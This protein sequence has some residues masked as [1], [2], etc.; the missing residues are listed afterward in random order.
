MDLDRAGPKIDG[1]TL[2]LSALPLELRLDIYE[3]CIPCMWHRKRRVLLDYL[4]DCRWMGTSPAIFHDAAPLVLRNPVLF[5]HTKLEVEGNLNFDFERLVEKTFPNDFQWVPGIAK[6]MV[7]RLAVTIRFPK[8]YNKS[9]N[10]VDRMSE[11]F[12]NIDQFSSLKELYI[13]LGPEYL[14]IEREEF[15]VQVASKEVFEPENVA[16]TPAASP[17][18]CPL[19]QAVSKLKDEIP[20]KCKVAWRFDRAGMPSMPSYIVDRTE[21]VEHLTNVNNSMERLWR[22]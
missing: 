12:G 19:A 2:L 4:V 6:S 7:Q 16:D 20:R 22:Q 17:M 10:L 9:N 18:P 8:F 3:I 13:S 21:V 14:P 15:D 1:L 11:Y 5:V